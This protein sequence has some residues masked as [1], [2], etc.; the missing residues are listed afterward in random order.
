[1]RDYQRRKLGDLMV[2]FY[3]K[4]KHKEEID[5]ELQLDSSCTD[6]ST[7]NAL[8]ELRPNF[9]LKMKEVINREINAYSDQKYKGK[10]PFLQLV[11]KSPANFSNGFYEIDHRIRTTHSALKGDGTSILLSN[12]CVRDIMENKLSSFE[13]IDKGYS[14]QL[15]ESNKHSKYTFLRKTRNQS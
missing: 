11:D 12:I 5:Q 9:P 4:L 14:S 10:S 6:I 7:S 8:R 15:N 13:K 1:M 2:N 3:G